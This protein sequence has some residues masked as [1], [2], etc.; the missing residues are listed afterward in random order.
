MTA[1]R[2]PAAES[3]GSSRKEGCGSIRLA[4]ALVYS[5]GL[6][7]PNLW[8]RLAHAEGEA[9]TADIQANE[10]VP[11]AVHIIMPTK[12]IVGLTSKDLIGAA[13]TILAKGDATDF[14]P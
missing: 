3:K 1:T 14:Q 2:P 12:E 8:P 6:L 13:A 11:L 7:V 4:V 5:P 10:R 9:K